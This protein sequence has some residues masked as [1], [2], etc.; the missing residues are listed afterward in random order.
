[1]LVYLPQV[2][3]YLPFSFVWRNSPTPQWARASSFT[4]FLYHTQRRTTGRV[5][6]SSQRPL[7]DNT[8]HLRH[9]WPRWDWNPQSQQ[10]SGHWD[11]LPI[12]LTFSKIS[13]NIYPKISISQ[14][15]IYLAMVDFDWLSACAII[16]RKVLEKQINC[17]VFG[18]KRPCVVWLSFPRWV[19]EY[20]RI[21]WKK[22]L[23]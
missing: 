21:L 10:A 14:C 13:I 18:M 2:S 16:R 1:M 19:E 22:M 17:N 9:P 8:Q 15:L 7:P 12:Y 20:W 5:I 3:P 4:R 11:R 23:Y 6:S